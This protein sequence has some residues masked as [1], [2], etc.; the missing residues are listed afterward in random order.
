MELMTCTNSEVQNIRRTYIDELDLD[1]DR[2]E[3]FEVNVRTLPADAQSILQ[4]DSPITTSTSWKSPRKSTPNT[5]R[6]E[7]IWKSQIDHTTSLGEIAHRFQGFLLSP[8]TELPFSRRRGRYTTKAAHRC[9]GYN[10][11][12]ITL[13]T[14]ITRSAIV[15]HLTPT[16]HE[17]CPI[18]E[19]IVKDAEIFAC[20]CGGEGKPLHEHNLS[21][22]MLTALADNE[23]IP[24]IR[25]LICSEWHHRPCVNMFEDGDHI[26]ACQR[27]KIRTLPG[28]NK[29]TPQVPPSRSSDAAEFEPD[30]EWKEHLKKKIEGELTSMVQAAKD[31]QMEELKRGPISASDRDR[32]EHEYQKAMKN[33]RTIADERYVVE[34]NR[35]RNQRRWIGGAPM[36]PRWVRVLHEEQEDILASIKQPRYSKSQSPSG[37]FATE[38]IA[39]DNQDEPNGRGIAEPG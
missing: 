24:T 6:R 19:E 15:S 3:E 1:Q 31:T 12:E 27:C 7:L 22:C 2:S 39:E 36:D 14:D 28:L 25:C 9:P 23:S 29:S 18:C 11:V 4:S 8:S 38:I 13:T 5:C 30:D 35:E 26:F 20:I 16:P 34:L 17:I 10:R 21:P 32:L 33:I 37:R